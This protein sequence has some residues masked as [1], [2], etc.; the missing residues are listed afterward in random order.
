M[1][2]LVD[3]VAASYMNPL[4]VSRA[5]LE[6]VPSL[7]CEH[8]TSLSLAASFLLFFFNYN[9]KYNNNNIIRERGREKPSVHSLRVGLIVGSVAG[10]FLLLPLGPKVSTV[11]R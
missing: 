8:S 9:Y 2:P 7:P 6:L 1:C 3:P 5:H 11:Q 10:A 4:M